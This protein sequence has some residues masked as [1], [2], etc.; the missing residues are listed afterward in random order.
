M[1]INTTGGSGLYIGGTTAIDFT[2]DQSA[3]DAFEAITDWIK[4][5]EIEDLGEIGDSSAD[6]TFNAL[7]ANRVRHLK[8]SRDAGTMTVVAGADP[9][10]P[11]QKAL[12]AAEKTKFNYNFRI[13][14]EDAPDAA[15]TDSVDYFRA[16]VMS[17]R[18]QNGTADNVM[19][20]TFALGINSPVITVDSDAV[21]ALTLSPAAGALTGGTKDSVYAG[22][23]VNVSNQIAPCT[24]SVVAGALP[25]G[26]TLNA[27]TGMLSGTPTT[28]GS[29]SFTVR[30]TDIY[31]NTGSAAYTLTVAA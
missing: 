30:A 20:R 25:A 10:D 31:G 3:L 12:C 9:Q 21:L 8:G 15:S 5:G 28:A 24:F 13:I 4:V 23:D 11:G 29:Y 18:K 16:L 26:I 1:A 17:A 2:T 22:V 19:R 6:V 27:S 14:Y 7:G